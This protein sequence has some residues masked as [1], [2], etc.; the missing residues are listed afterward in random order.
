MY[1]RVAVLYN[2]PV[3][4]RYN[5]QE[6]VAVTDVLKAVLAV[7]NSLIESGHTVILIPLIP[8]VNGLRNTLQSL[9]TDVVFNLFEGF[10]ESSET[11]ALVPEILEELRIPYTGC[12]G[13]TLRLAL[14]KATAKKILKL[15]KINT[16]D[17]QVLSPAT[18]SSFNLSYPCIVKP[19]EE[20][21]SHGLTADSVVSDYS[22]LKRQVSFISSAFGGDALVEEFIGGREFNATVIGN[23]DYQVL[24]VSEIVYDL[25]K[26]LPKVLTFEAKW[27]EDSPYYI[28][29]K[30]VCPAK[31]LPSENQVIIDIVLKIARLFECRGYARVDMR[32]DKNG[33]I[34]VIEIN[35]NPDISPG[36][37]TVRQVNA[38]H[39]P[40][41]DFVNKIISLAM[42]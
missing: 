33:M 3:V 18:I 14:D 2:K 6:A 24:P 23:K 4:Q 32:Q 20:D 25:P 31:I 29:T 22:S 21:A 15:E 11:E 34:N 36:A 30:V 16:P 39:M 27:N 12:S 37:G 35:P 40:Y 17:F 19:R 8:P 1:K 28:G 42:E 38:A 9:D 10:D 26:E 7:E 13:K 5:S 41:T